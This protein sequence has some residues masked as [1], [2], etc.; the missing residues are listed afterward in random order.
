MAVTTK[1]HVDEGISANG[2]A[3]GELESFN[4]AT[5]ERIGSVPTITPEQVQGVVDDVAEVQPFWAQLSLAERAAYL[6][7][8][9]Q[10]L[11][12]HSDEIAELITREQGKPRLESYTMEVLPTVD[13]LHWCADN[14]PKILADEPVR[15]PQLMLKQK[16]SAFSYEPIGVVGVIAPWNYPWSIPF[17]EVAIALMAGNGVVLKP[18]SLTPLIGQRIQEVFERAGLPGGARADGARRRRGRTG[19][20]RVAPREDLLHRLGRGRPRRRRGVRAAD[21][22]LRARARRQGPADR[23]RRRQPRQCDLRRG[24]GRVR[25]CRPD[26]LGHRARLRRATMSPSASSRASS[27]AQ[28]LTVGDPLDWDTEIGPMVSSEQFDLVRELVDD[29]V[30]IGRDAALRRPGR[31]RRAS[32]ALHR[33]DRAHR[34][35][36]RH[37]DH[38]RGDLRPRRS[39]S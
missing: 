24:L 23:V 11:L 32:A 3:P 9:A 21:E 30:A 39:R 13:A 28:R 4:P 37:A 26:L 8:A 15:Y 14:G 34:R 1:G 27:R 16:K 31:G 19:A 5:G 22:G 38:A 29:A 18:A 10:V 35:H 17:G 25:Q 20:G 2:G 36:P 12:D 7:R 6:R 33:A